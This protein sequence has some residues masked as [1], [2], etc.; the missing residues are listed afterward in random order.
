[1]NPIKDCYGF[2]LDKESFHQTKSLAHS[3]QFPIKNNEDFFFFFFEDRIIRISYLLKRST[4]D[5]LKYL[6]IFF[7]S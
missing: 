1:M 3:T 7:Y 6:V 2:N 5:V 4:F